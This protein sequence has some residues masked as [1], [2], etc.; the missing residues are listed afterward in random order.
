MIRIGWDRLATGTL[1][2][3]DMFGRAVYRENINK[4]FSKNIDVSRWSAANYFVQFKSST[5]RTY[6]KRLA[7]LH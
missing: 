5:G 2:I 6:S 1:E 7:I 3:F 4:S